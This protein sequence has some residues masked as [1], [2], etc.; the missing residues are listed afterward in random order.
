L[1]IDGVLVSSATL[2]GALTTN[3]NP[4][5]IGARSDGTGALNGRID[6]LRIT[7]GVAR[8]TANFTP[9]TAPFPNA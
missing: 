6:D 7:K 3:A 2:A 5:Y 4:V 1:F 8:Y 9:P